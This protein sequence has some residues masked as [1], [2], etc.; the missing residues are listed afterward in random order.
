MEE[1]KM[2]TMRSP[3]EKERIV[4]EA[5]EHGPN[6]T[7]RKFDVNRRLLQRWVVKYRNN[8][9]DGLRSQ[10]G[11]HKVKHSNG[12]KGL[13]VKKNKTREEE[14]ELENLK[15]KVE[16]ARLKNAS[17]RNSDR[18]YNRVQE[19]SEYAEEKFSQYNFGIHLFLNK[20][21]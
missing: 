16:V 7:A 10:T 20:N 19:C 17:S 18:Q 9:L 13:H 6:K 1:K 14:L 21:R 2:K 4:L 3:E 5:I 8:G 12:L 11:R 15:L